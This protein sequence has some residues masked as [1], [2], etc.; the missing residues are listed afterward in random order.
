MYAI[1][2]L[3]SFAII[4]SLIYFIFKKYDHKEALT[5]IA[6]SFL[7][8][9]TLMAGGATFTYS[10]KIPEPLPLPVVRMP[11]VQR[12]VVTQMAPTIA[13]PIYNW[14]KVQRNSVLIVAPETQ[15]IG[16]DNLHWGMNA[17][18]KNDA[19][20]AT[21]DLMIE[22]STTTCEKINHTKNNCQKSQNHYIKTVSNFHIPP[23]G[24][25][26]LAFN[27]TTPKPIQKT[28][29][30]YRVVKITQETNE[31]SLVDTKP[32]CGDCG[33]SSNISHIS[34]NV[35]EGSQI[36]WPARGRIIK[37]FEN[38]GDGVNIAIPEGTQVKAAEAGEVAF[39]GSQLAGYG[40]MV[41]IRH[42]NGYATSY[43][44]NQELLVKRG[45]HVEMGQTIARSGM[46]GNVDSPQLHFEVRY[47]TT[48]IDPVACLQ[49]R[50]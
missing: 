29:I 31:P 17:I 5:I 9:F 38:G 43:A 6:I 10:A 44:H 32:T 33:R 35:C 11:L 28:T 19:N 15:R 39:S 4:S 26:K 3:S 27:F 45:D 22:I 47:G 1:F 30:H 46:T 2:F 20:Y 42:N 48:P 37:V 23:N 18:I 49:K 13:K 7:V 21:N 12:N 24:I 16:Q 41:I 8:V 36:G 25:S 34:D 40:N 14:Q 50:A